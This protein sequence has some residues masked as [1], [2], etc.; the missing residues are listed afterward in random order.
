MMT[1]FAEVKLFST[2]TNGMRNPLH[3]RCTFTNT[4]GLVNYLLQDNGIATVKAT[5]LESVKK[6]IFS[7]SPPVQSTSP[8]Q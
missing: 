6:M 8:V 1:S 5:G 7:V 3:A 2:I 4:E